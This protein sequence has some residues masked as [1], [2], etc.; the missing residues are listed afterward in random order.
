MKMYDDLKGKTCVVTGAA[1]VLCSA[2]VEALCE[3]G[4]KVALL[5]RTEEKLLALS[6]KL[7]AKGFEKTLPIRADVLVREDLER[8]QEQVLEAFGPVYLLVNG[9]GGNTPKAVTQSEILEGTS[10]EDLARGFFGTDMEAFR[11]VFDL[12]FMGTL[13]P[14]MVFGKSMIKSGSGNIIN[15]S[16][17]SAINP[18]TKVAAYSAAKASIDNFTRW[19]AVHFA[20]MKVRVNAIAPGFFSTV[21]NR[22]LLYEEDGTT[23]TPRGNKIITHTPMEEFGRPEDLKGALLYL[24]SN[25]QS[26][27]VTGIVLPVDGGFSAY[28]GV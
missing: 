24:A 6:E 4:A 20:K 1:G 22:F 26:R 25:D 7:K 21:Q 14:C 5:G 8:A 23:L 11:F 17:M 28:P 10:D 18:L 13:L 27:F 12:N 15:I 19:L 2:M 16:S 9:A 3:A